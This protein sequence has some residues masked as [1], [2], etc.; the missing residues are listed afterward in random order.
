MGRLRLAL[1]NLYRP[2]APTAGIVASLG[3]GL[4]VLV[5]IAL[6]ERNIAGR[7]KRGALD[8][9][10]VMPVLGGTITKW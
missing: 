3:L 2:G 9:D 4:T 1:A 5:A 6:I 10:Y 7:K 8:V